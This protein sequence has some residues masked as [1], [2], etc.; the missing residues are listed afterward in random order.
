MT[1]HAALIHANVIGIEAN[2]I[3]AADAR[4]KCEHDAGMFAEVSA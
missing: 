2:E 4:R 3:Y 1:L